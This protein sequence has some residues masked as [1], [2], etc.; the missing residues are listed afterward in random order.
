[1]VREVAW[2]NISVMLFRGM[3][4]SSSASWAGMESRPGYGS[5][6]IAPCS[7][8][9][10]GTAELQGAHDRQQSAADE[11]IVIPP[12]RRKFRLITPE[13]TAI[14]RCVMAEPD[15]R[16]GSSS[17]CAALSYAPISTSHELN[18]CPVPVG[19]KADSRRRGSTFR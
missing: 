6:A 5:R 12:L 18:L 14:D 1:M 11:V 4:P 2:A 15:F 10:T 13:I 16:Q 3:L 9:L 17:M 19:E 7:A 8:V